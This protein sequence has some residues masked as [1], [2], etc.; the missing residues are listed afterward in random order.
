MSASVG[1]SS[2]FYSAKHLQTGGGELGGSSPALPLPLLSVLQISG[3]LPR[4][5]YTGHNLYQGTSP[6]RFQG[7]GGHGLAVTLPDGAMD[8]S[9]FLSLFK[10]FPMHMGWQQQL[11]TPPSG[12]IP[13]DLFPSL[14]PG[15][16]EQ[17]W[18]H[19]VLPGVSEAAEQMHLH[20]TPR[21]L[22]AER[23]KRV[24][25][26]EK[27]AG[28]HMEIGRRCSFLIKCEFCCCYGNRTG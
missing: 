9:A 25:R 18:G 23:M 12:Y 24:Q 6:G 11:S 5:I 19:P 16:R 22:P 20:G 1:W 8:S 14:W 2:C 3:S 26:K 10:S 17:L 27:I 4:Q 28:G 7:C 13:A 21:E 15:F